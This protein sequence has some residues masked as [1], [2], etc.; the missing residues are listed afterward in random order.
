MPKK[1]LC[2]GFSLGCLISLFSLF[3][4][5]CLSNGDLKGAIDTCQGRL[6]RRISLLTYNKCSKCEKPGK[7]N[8]KTITTV[9]HLQIG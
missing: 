8:L 6:H 7:T 9:A 4:F 1:T 5:F 2:L 3:F